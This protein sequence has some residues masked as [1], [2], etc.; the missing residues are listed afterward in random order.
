MTELATQILRFASLLSTN[1]EAANRAGRGAPEGLCVVAAEQTAGRGRLERQWVSPRNAG[2]YFSIVLRPRLPQS[3]WP[4]FA[5][6][7]ALAV[8]D[9]LLDACS[10]A[11]DIK[12]PNDVLFNERKLCGI[13]AET[14]E[15]S[16]GRALVIGIGINLNKTAL[17]PELEPVA[18][19]VESATGFAPNLE[20]V[21]QKL[22]AAFAG[23]YSRAQSPESAVAI[24]EE[25]CRRSSYCRRKRV[26]VTQNDEIF[27]GTTDGLE[28]DGAL[29]ISTDNGAIKIVRAGDVTSVRPFDDQVGN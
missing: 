26:L 7:S 17:P 9:A 10:L 12:W 4:L 1:L 19:S 2:L 24:V 28:A 21:L 11:T 23:H 13:L 15:S 16:F 6:M 8:Q 5:L 25:W 22:V 20:V 14:V 3:S 29:R 27:V 18:T